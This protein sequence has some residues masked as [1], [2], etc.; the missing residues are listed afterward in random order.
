MTNLLLSK[1]C[2]RLGSLLVATF[3]SLITVATATSAAAV[4]T[5]CTHQ[6]GA[7]SAVT[8]T[9]DNQDGSTNSADGSGFMACVF[10]NGSEAYSIVI[11]KDDGTEDLGADNLGRTFRLGFTLPAGQSATS[12]E[13]YA[14]VQSYTIADHGRDIALVMKPVSVTSA[15]DTDSPQ[16]LQDSLASVVGGIRFN[17]TGSPPHGVIG[18]WIGASA[19]RYSVSLSGSCPNFQSGGP[20]GSTAAGAIS[21]R[22]WAPHMT[23]GTLT[24]PVLNTGSLKAFIPTEAA[25][26]C[27]GGAT[28]DAIVAALEVARSAAAEGETALTPGSQFTATAL[29]DG[30]L[31]DVPTVTFSSPTYIIS[32]PKLVPR[33]PD[34]IKKV[35]ATARREGSKAIVK[36]NV[37]A[38]YKGKRIVVTE[39][40]GKRSRTLV[41]TKAKAG[42]NIFT[43]KVSAKK[44]KAFLKVTLNAKIVATLKV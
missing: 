13:L 32:A 7:L 30:L 2:R 38:A 5:A 34:S 1:N 41:A 37:P 36:V 28:L 11:A 39:I 24:A 22:L 29:S 40:I 19:N 20:S 4:S 16:P 43:V 26:A 8:L 25:S 12:A 42:V 23:A 44:G 17:S 3:C 27:F 18:M 35:S 10:P 15:T 21:V 31:I 14:D 33:I 6:A 9:V